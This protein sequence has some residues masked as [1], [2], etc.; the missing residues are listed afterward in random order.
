MLVCH[1]YGIRE[2][3]IRKAI[4]NGA[5]SLQQVQR[6]CF[7]GSGCGTC[8]EAVNEI[9]EDEAASTEA[10]SDASAPAPLAAG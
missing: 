8:R 4:R 9:L 3:R 7:A 1:C 5:S 10:Q 6:A 2:A